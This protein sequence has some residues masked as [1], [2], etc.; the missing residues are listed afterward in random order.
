VPIIHKNLATGHFSQ[1]SF[2]EQMANIGSEV[3]RALNWKERNNDDYSQ[4]AFER[5]LDLI[6]ITMAGITDLSRLKELSRI[7]EVLNDY[8]RGDNQFFSTNASWREYFLCF[9][10][11]ARKSY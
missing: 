3:E 6:G 2:C 7:R 5:A 8:F 1:M 9:A 10:F 4:K 11:A